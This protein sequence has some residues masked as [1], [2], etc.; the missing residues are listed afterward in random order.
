MDAKH[1][2]D[3]LRQTVLGETEF[4]RAWD[5]FFH[6]SELPRFMRHSQHVRHELLE[7][8][9]ECICQ[10]MLHGDAPDAGNGKG[11][12]VVEQCMVLEY[13]GTGFHHGFLMAAGSP[14]NFM[15]FKDGDLGMV[16]LLQPGGQSRMCRFSLAVSS[17]T[18]A[19]FLPPT[20]GGS[21]VH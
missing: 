18:V 19:P 15:Y 9:L 1:D 16:L 3:T 11:R 7:N 13:A 5:A 8:V 21:S 12:R 4:A 17:S 10:S 20:D 2:V 14:G 6:L